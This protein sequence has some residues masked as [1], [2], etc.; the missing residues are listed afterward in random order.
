MT[1]VRMGIAAFAGAVVALVLA[2]VFY[3]V[4]APSA[5]E[6]LLRRE[7]AALATSDPVWREIA[8]VDP[9]IG[10]R[11][12]A[13]LAPAYRRGIPADAIRAK[14]RD[15]GAQTLMGMIV[16]KGAS[17]PDDALVGLI[18]AIATALEELARQ[19]EAACHASCLPS[20]GSS[21]LPR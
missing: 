17:A 5:R 6:W 18:R 8:Y 16:T 9:T 4:V 7:M 2:P 21:P 15:F 20:V 12:A 3:G 1:W 13:E 10:D 19:D 11:L 14:A